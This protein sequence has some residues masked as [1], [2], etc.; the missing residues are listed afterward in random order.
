MNK[1]VNLWEPEEY[2][3]IV[4]YYPTN[5]AQETRQTNKQNSTLILTVSC[6]ERSCKIRS[7]K[8]NHNNINIIV[9]KKRE[10]KRD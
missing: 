8:K 5:S 4:D 10:K 7:K 9:I 3:E 2:N 6:H 1:I